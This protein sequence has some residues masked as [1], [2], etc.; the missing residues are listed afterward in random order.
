MLSQGPGGCAES[1]HAPLLHALSHAYAVSWRGEHSSGLLPTCPSFLR[2]CE[3]S[4]ALRQVYDPITEGCLVKG[5]KTGS[6]LG[7]SRT[8]R[9]LGIIATFVVSGLIHEFIFW[10]ARL[11][12]SLCLV[13]CHA[14]WMRPA[15]PRWL[16]GPDSTWHPSGKLFCM[17]LHLR[18]YSRSHVPRF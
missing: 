10:C 13:P 17:A 11:R 12:A 5:A 14:A 7:P 16:T 3:V 1:S 6:A 4:I 15:R 8:L 18:E 2:E 9:R